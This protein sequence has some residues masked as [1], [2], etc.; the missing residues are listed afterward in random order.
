MTRSMSPLLCMNRTCTSFP[1][2]L[3]MLGLV[4]NFSQFR[5]SPTS[6]FFFFLLGICYL[7]DSSELKFLSKLSNWSIPPT[8]LEQKQTLKLSTSR[9]PKTL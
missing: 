4:S 5:P 1:V 7:S 6:F 2:Y 3:G 8:Y 9:K